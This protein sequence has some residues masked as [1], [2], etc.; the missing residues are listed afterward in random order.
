MSADKIEVI[1]IGTEPPCPRCDLLNRHVRNVLSGA[2]GNIS[3]VHLPF[4]SPE[5]Q[6]LGRKFGRKVGTAKQVAEAAG[7]NMNWQAVYEIIEHQKTIFREACAPAD[8]WS[9]ELDSALEPCQRVADSVGYLMTP[10]LIVKGEVKHHGSVPSL[11]D[12]R[13]WVLGHEKDVL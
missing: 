2:E 8:L 9:P 6:D 1:V 4:D 7:I 10:V 11:D 5:A 12:V 13:S 3:H